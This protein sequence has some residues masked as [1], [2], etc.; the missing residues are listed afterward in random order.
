MP[1]GNTP[2][3]ALIGKDARRSAR[4]GAAD[5]DVRAVSLEGVT[6]RYA[7]RQADALHEVT[8]AFPRCSFTAVMGLS[9]SGKSTL[10]QCAGGLDRPTSGV[11]RLGGQDLAS[12]SRRQLSVLRR[13]RVGFVFQALN[14]VPTLTVSENI[15]LPL[16]LDQ[17]RVDRKQLTD[18]AQRVGIADHL[19]RLPDTLSGGQQQRTAIARALITDPEVILADEP[20]A[21]LDPYTGEAVL[22]LLRQA[23]DDLRQTVIVVTHNP[24]VAAYADRVVLLS[25]GKLAGIVE[26]PDEAELNSILRRLGGGVA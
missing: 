14:L 6:K 19:R 5:A 2:A 11:V 4:K 17:R 7:R 8:V 20:T 23:V 16:R 12:L 22:A 18:L 26:A 3:R 21:A 13:Q 9:G 10:L 1:S 15:A 25:K 24:V